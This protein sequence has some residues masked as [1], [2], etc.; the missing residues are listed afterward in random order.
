MTALIAFLGAGYVSIMV[1]WLR[2]AARKMVLLNII[3][4]LMAQVFVLL[5]LGLSLELKRAGGDA[6]WRHSVGSM[7]VTLEHLLDRPANSA[8]IQSLI[9]TNTMGVSKIG[10]QSLQGLYLSLY[11]LEEEN[12]A[13]NRKG[14]PGSVP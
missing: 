12:A 6:L 4:G 7:L 9:R 11:R 14:A 5:L 13:A 8:R 3:Y 1:L 10:F 2:S